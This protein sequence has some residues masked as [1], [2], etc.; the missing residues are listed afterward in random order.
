MSCSAAVITHLML[1]L[2][3]STVSF[4]AKLKK[5]RQVTLRQD[6]PY[7]L[8]IFIMDLKSR[9]FCRSHPSFLE[10]TKGKKP[11]KI[12]V[13]GPLLFRCPFWKQVMSRSQKIQKKVPK[14]INN[15]PFYQIATMFFHHFCHFLDHFLTYKWSSTKIPEF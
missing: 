10:Y 14:S 12:K 15:W 9:S 2:K 1:L 5:N 3:S 8:T 13:E 7:P 11:V 6:G 4:C